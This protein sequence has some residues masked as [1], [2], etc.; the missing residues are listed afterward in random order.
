MILIRFLMPA[1]WEINNWLSNV[2]TFETLVFQFT[3]D[4]WVLGF[5][6]VSLL[7]AVIFYEA[8]YLDSGSHINILTGTMILTAFGLLS[9][10]SG[11]GL[12]FLLTWVLIDIAEFLILVG[13]IKDGAKHRISII[14]LLARFLGIILM[15]SYLILQTPGSVL[16][17]EGGNL[18]TGVLLIIIVLLRMGIIPLHIPYSEEPKIR[19]GIGSI[20]RFLPILSV[21]SF[22]I[23]S[24]P[25]LFSKIQY[26]GT[27]TIVTAG[28]LFG[29]LSWFFARSELDGRPYWVFA[30]GCL[31]L[32]AFLRGA[33]D[34]LVGISIVM[35]VGGSVLFLFLPRKQ[36]ASVLL[37]LIL[38]VMFAIP[39]TPTAAIPQAIWGGRLEVANFFL[40]IS[41]A[42]LIGGVIRHSLRIED[43]RKQ[44]EDWV[45]LFQIAGLIVVAA[46]PWIAEIFSLEKLRSLD[47]WWFSVSLVAIIGMAIIFDFLQRRSATKFLGRFK[48]P[49]IRMQPVILYIDKFFRFNWVVRWFEAVGK[50]IE[51]AI[52]FL[53]RI[54]EGDGGIVWSFLLLILL[55]SL[56]LAAQVQ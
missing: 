20:L 31:A 13:I 21:F 23:F 15:L 53:V 9:I 32:I 8:R 7:V 52:G 28:V 42:L 30:Y 25:Q 40:L 14:S 24:G 17:V 54:L 55:A 51:S 45:W 39:Y 34:A 10:Q 6:L 18:S 44:L 11:N 35:V 5:L 26:G 43:K 22:I 3:K 36:K 27:L 33:V 49:L 1:G 16:S 29:A 41:L 38:P 50:F 56:L 19:R 12:T 48:E 46:A 4:T 2:S 47:Y 37:P